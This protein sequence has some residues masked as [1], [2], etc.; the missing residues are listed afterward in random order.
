MVMIRKK[1]VLK[2]AGAKKKPAAKKKT[3]SK[4]ASL[5][6]KKKAV[7]PKKAPAPGLENEIGQVVAFFRLPVVA[8]IKITKRTLKLGDQIWIKG[9]TT[10]LK[11]T[12]ASMQIDHKPI[13][14]AKKGDE[15]GVKVSSRCRRG[16]RVYLVTS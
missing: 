6:S 1:K 4:K 3:A 2:K 10:D 14:Q 13:Q 5:S 16:D 8:V 15:F 7:S 12:L 9:H 11:Q